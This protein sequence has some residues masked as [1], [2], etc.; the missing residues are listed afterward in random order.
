M[1]RAGV[2]PLRLGLCCVFVAEP[3]RFRR[4][5]ARHAGR[6]SVVERREHLRQIALAN[7]GALTQAISWCLAHGVAAFRVNSEILPLC[8]H[9]TLGYRLHEI[10]PDGAIVAAFGEARD[11]ARRG[12]LRLSLHPDQF[13]VPGSIREAVSQSSLAELEAQARFAELVG[14]E[15]IT[16]HGGGAQGGKPAALERLARSLARLS[17]R[18]RSRLA[19][20]N[21]DR[22]YTVENL[23]PV[24]RAQGIPLV[25]DVHHHRCH[26]DRLSVAEAT[27]LAASTWGQREPWVHLS[28]PKEG[29]QGDNPRSHADYIRPRD[30]PACWFGRVM[31]IDVE[32]KAKELAVLRLARWFRAA[33]PGAGSTP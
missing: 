29:W 32:A 3:I 4:T 17:P 16:L 1:T 19:L 20:E 30:V 26:Q 11:R 23:L 18:A 13:V 14:A 31:T 5:T 10:D 9:P 8:T 2:A 28:S 15:Q 12:R 6:M 25:Y 27:D 24:C 21:D 22:V 7:A 33:H